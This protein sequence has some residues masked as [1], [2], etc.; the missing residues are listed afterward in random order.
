VHYAVKY[1]GWDGKSDLRNLPEP[2][3]GVV[4][5]PLWVYIF[6]HVSFPTPACCVRLCMIV[7]WTQT[8]VEWI[9]FSMYIS[10]KR[11]DITEERIDAIFNAEWGDGKKCL[12]PNVL[13]LHDYLLWF[14]THEQRFSHVDE[15]V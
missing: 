11:D 12:T 6:T 8:I 3:P 5:S 10:L 1:R 15:E 9:P 13:A 7:C 4:V 2:C 14:P